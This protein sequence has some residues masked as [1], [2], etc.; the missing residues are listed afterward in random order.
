MKQRRL[1]ASVLVAA[2]VL[3]AGCGGGGG[4]SGGTAATTTA[5]T[6]AT[7]APTVD[8]VDYPDGLSAEGY[9]NDSTAM[10]T[11]RSA[12]A[13]GPSYTTR[14]DVE[15]EGVTQTLVARTNP[16]EQVSYAQTERNGSVRYELYYANGT[17]YL[18][19]AEGSQAQYGNTNATFEGVITG[20]N[21]G[22][23]LQQLSLLD[24]E[25]TGV[26]EVDGRTIITYDV[27][28][29]RSSETGAESASGQVQVTT[30]GQLVSFEYIVV[31]A[32]GQ[33]L[34]VSWEQTNVGST[35]VSEPDWL[36]QAR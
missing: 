8:T 25:A 31:S 9:E 30:E 3:V 20:Y 34:S 24:L 32:Q 10:S 4:G 21:G 36:S 14:M 35:T 6:T 12:L 29:P 15:S 18:R 5:T 27:T 33:E 13:S 2:L 22:Q 19:N 26:E 16:G 17:Q 7:P 28:G 11:F 1:F 23:F